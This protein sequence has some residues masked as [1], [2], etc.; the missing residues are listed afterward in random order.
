M[1]AMNERKMAVQAESCHGTAFR[2]SRA[3]LT[4]LHSSGKR[5][6]TCPSFLVPKPNNDNTNMHLNT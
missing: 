2:K 4:L 3:M 1:T 6:K 5:Q